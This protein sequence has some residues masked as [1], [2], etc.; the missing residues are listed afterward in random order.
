MS[1]D[2]PLAPCRAKRSFDATDEPSG[3]HPASPSL[4]PCF[5]VQRHAA[6]ALHYDLRLEV[7][8]VLASW[9]V[10]KGPS[11]DPSVERLAI[12]VE[13]H[14]LD[15]AG[16]EGTI[17]KASYGAGSV[18]VW[19]TGTF[20][21]RSE[22]HGRAVDLRAAID[23]G[24]V[25][26]F[27]HGQKLQGCWSLIRTRCLRPGQDAWLLVKAADRF[28]DRSRD[29]VADE[30]ASVLTGRTN[31]QVAADAPAR[32]EP[33]LVG[34]RPVMLARPATLEML[35]RVGAAGGW[36]YERKLDGVRCLAV[37]YH[38][39]VQLWSRNRQSF[40]ER[41]APIAEVMRSWAPVEFALDGEIVAFDGGR[42][43][44]G[45]LQRPSAT[46]EIRFLVFD[47]LALLGRDTT[48]LVLEERRQLLARLVPD[49]GPVARLAVLDGQPAELLAS[50]CDQ[51]WEG[52]LAKRLG[53]R[54]VAGRS[55]DWLKL[56]CLASQEVVI[57]GWTDPKGARLG[58]GALL[59]GYYH[60][61]RLRYA[62]KVGTG[63]DDATLRE[64]HGRLVSL[65]RATSPFADPVPERS[66]HWVE[67]VLVAQVSFGEWTPDGR[68]R[69]PSFGG[70]RSDKPATEVVR[71]DPR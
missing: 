35:E 6:R 30:P 69:H 39:R 32:P 71:E 36:T 45:H 66:P 34:W 59:T 51:G 67:P 21:N 42:T 44:F 47:L 38:D 1:D 29:V 23:A 28:A 33:R 63:F 48:G 40:T 49:S 14:P 68:L 43:S 20:E 52:L 11:Y 26:V 27:L 24:H 12:H 57:G 9:A 4:A 17:P 5:V 16:F 25:S 50:A 65:A 18:V 46:T 61:G 53:S 8:G 37:R 3:Q 54:Y 55:N 64:L 10:P 15:Y 41:F 62:G 56:K 70:L 60:D 19:D 2:D 31:E 58:F 22:R 7:E 13:D